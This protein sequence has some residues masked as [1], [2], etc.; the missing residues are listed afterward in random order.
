MKGDGDFFFPNIAKGKKD[1]FPL[2]V[3]IS[4]FRK[5]P[6]VLFFTFQH[7]SVYL[8]NKPETFFPLTK[9]T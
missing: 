6:I 9:L 1:L 4:S 8:F 2:V 5:V 7:L 3:S